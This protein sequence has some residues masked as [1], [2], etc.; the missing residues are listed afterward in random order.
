MVGRWRWEARDLEMA[1]SVAQLP[2]G[3][4]GTMHGRQVNQESKSPFT[5]WGRDPA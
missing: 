4:R 5:R 3:G 1:V 2:L